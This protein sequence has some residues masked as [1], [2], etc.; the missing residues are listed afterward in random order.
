MRRTHKLAAVVVATLATSPLLGMGAGL[1]AEGDT[2]ANLQPSPLN[3]IDGSGTAMVQVDGT[4][5]T[6]TLSATGLLPDAPHAAH[7]HFAAD[8]LHECPTA[9]RDADGSGTLNTTEGL[10]DYGPVVV[11]LT[12]TGA[13]DAESILAIDRFDTAPGGELSY[14]RGSI[15]VAPEIATAIADGLSVVVVHGVDYNESGEYDGKTKSDLDPSLPTEAT[16]PALCGT[17]LAAPSGGP[18]TG[19][20]GASTHANAGILAIGGGLVLLA[21]GSIVVGTRRIRATA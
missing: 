8:A 19:Y 5:I 3:G 6:V 11:S 10:P 7:I 2:T 12:K 1:A 17:L 16:D 21:A 15:N 20:G 9:A 13:T 18:E 4:Q 14:E